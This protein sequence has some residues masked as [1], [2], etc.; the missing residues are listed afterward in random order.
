MQ[1]FK[2]KTGF[3]FL[4]ERETRLKQRWF[5]YSPPETFSHMFRSPDWLL[6]KDGDLTGSVKAMYEHT[7]DGERENDRSKVWA[8]NGVAVHR[9]QVVD[10]ASLADPGSALNYLLTYLAVT[11]PDEDRIIIDGDACTA[12]GVDL[13]D[14]DFLIHDED[15]V[16]T[17]YEGEPRV[18]YRDLFWNAPPAEPGE[19]DDR[20]TYRRYA[21]LAE[22]LLAQPQAL[23]YTGP[24]SGLSLIQQLRPH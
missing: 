15:L 4:E 23:T 10:A 12:N 22:Q 6:W 9:L 1:T 13:P 24:W 21:E 20:P 11:H 18:M 8:R 14:V 2:G 16:M 5:H 19:D 3:A 17:K 7:Q